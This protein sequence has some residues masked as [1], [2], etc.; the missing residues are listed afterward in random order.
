MSWG[1]LVHCVSSGRAPTLA[2]TSMFIMWKFSHIHKM[3]AKNMMGRMG[4][5]HLWLTWV[6]YSWLKWVG[7]LGWNTY[8]LDECFWDINNHKVCRRPS[9]THGVR[10]D[11]CK[12]CRKPVEVWRVRFIRRIVCRKYGDDVLTT[13]KCIVG[14]ESSF[15]QLQS[16]LEVCRGSESLFW[17]QQSM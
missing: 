13:A 7:H 8:S 14:W 17:Q 1:Q 5:R 16:A 10:F 2:G 4:M 11:H 9:E 12:A 15:W 6:G 3:W